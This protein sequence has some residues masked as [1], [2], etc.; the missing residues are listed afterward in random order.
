MRRRPLRPVTRRDASL[1]ACPQRIVQSS[2]RRARDSS[3]LDICSDGDQ[4]D[5]EIH[6][7]K[8]DPP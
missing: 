7:R 3:A 1:D 6:A 4:R 2:Q 5:D 8:I